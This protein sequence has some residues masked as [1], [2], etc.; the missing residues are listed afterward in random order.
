[1]AKTKYTGKSIGKLKQM[2]QPK[3]NKF[4]RLR[5]GDENGMGKCI[6]CGKWKLLQAGHFYPVGAYDSLR[7]NENNCHGECAGCN[8]FDE[9]HLLNYKPNLIEKIGQA[10]FDELELLANQYR[11]NG[12]KWLRVD[13]IALIEHYQNEMR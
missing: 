10:N 5:D 4:I 11:M 8:G 6:S 3:F 9:M 1:M 2:L 12:W 13:L 7:F